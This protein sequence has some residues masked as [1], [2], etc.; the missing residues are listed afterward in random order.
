MKRSLVGEVGNLSAAQVANAFAEHQ[1]AIVVDIFLDVVVV[2]LIGN[3]GCAFLKIFQ[4]GVAPPIAEASKVIEL[5]PFVVEA[6]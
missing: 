3:A 1:F 6:V 4:V 2:E 5:R